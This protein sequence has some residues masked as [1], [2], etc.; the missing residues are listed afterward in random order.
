MNSAQ[1]AARGHAV[2]LSGLDVQ[3]CVQRKRAM[4]IVFKAMPLGA[5]RRQRQ[6]WVQPIQR[7]NRRLLIYAKHGSMLRR[8]HVQ[9]DNVS[10]LFLKTWIVGGHIAVQSMRLQPGLGQDA[11]HG[12]FAQAERSRQF[13]ARPVSGTIAGFLLRA[14]D[15]A[16]LHGRRGAPRFAA[17]VP[18]RQPSMPSC[19]NRPFHFDT[20]GALAPSECSNPLIRQLHLYRDLIQERTQEPN[21]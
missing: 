3:S 4:T 6:H 2:H 12:G 15:H 1:Y 18:A 11:L 14:P 7:L 10:G 21:P 13:P 5:A 19:S 17:L 9:A 20:V 8:I 16:P